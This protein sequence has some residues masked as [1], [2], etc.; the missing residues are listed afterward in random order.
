METQAFTNPISIK[1]QLEVDQY[2]KMEKDIKA[3][4]HDVLAREIRDLKKAMRN[5]QT[6]RGNK[7]LEYEDLCVQPDI[8]LP[9]GYKPLN[10]M[11]IGKVEK[12]TL[13]A[14]HASTMTTQEQALIEVTSTTAYMLLYNTETPIICGAEPEETLK[15]WTCTPFLVHRGSW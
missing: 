15:N 5:L 4:A 7:S 9:V 2:K 8:D 10:I 14:F 3:K 11:S 1:F 6:I 12:D 13:L